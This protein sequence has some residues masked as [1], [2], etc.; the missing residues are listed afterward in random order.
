MSFFGHTKAKFVFLAVAISASAFAKPLSPGKFADYRACYNGIQQLH[1]GSTGISELQTSWKHLFMRGTE[2]DGLEDGESIDYK[3]ELGGHDPRVL[4]LTSGK[5]LSFPVN[6]VKFGAGR[7]VVA[8]NLPP[9][10][11]TVVMEFSVHKLMENNF[12]FDPYD[13][14]LR[15][16]ADESVEKIIDARRMKSSFD[17]ATSDFTNTVRDSLKGL[18]A[19]VDEGLQ[20]L[21]DTNTFTN[22][23]SSGV[24]ALK[25]RFDEVLAA[26]KKA[27]IT[28]PGTPDVNLVDAI[29]ADIEAKFDAAHEELAQA[30]TGGTAKVPSAT[31]RPQ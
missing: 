5:Y 9:E 15:N 27:N 6:P 24:P 11:H 29:S 8:I 20:S 30:K 19:K 4:I 31:R 26:C 28:E 3:F 2:R 22:S 18:A 21:R 10:G 1:G 7:H 16:P 13:T 23:T 12:F 14:G 17:P 25:E